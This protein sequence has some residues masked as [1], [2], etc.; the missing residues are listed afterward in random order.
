M[1]GT[2]DEFYMKEALKQA[3]IALDNNE[4]PIGAVIVLGDRILAK[5]HNQTEL[6]N[7]PTAHAEMLAI[8]A[9]CNTI[10]SRHLHKCTL[11]VTVEPCIMCAGASFW[12]QLGRVV[13]G[14]SDNK[15]GYTTLNPNIFPAKIKV[16]QGIL[17]EECT[18]ILDVFFKQIRK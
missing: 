10:G 16:E 4:V 18:S 7:D 13:F 12:A 1:H 15:K 5:A 8:T 6:L 9:A 11:Y 17:E 2:T 3:K 14:A